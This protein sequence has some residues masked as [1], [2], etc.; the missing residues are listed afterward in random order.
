MKA[1]LP[2]S[3]LFLLFFFLLLSTGCTEKQQPI[4]SSLQVSAVTPS[5]DIPAVATKQATREDL[6][7]FVEKAV[8]FA[9][10]EG[11]AKALAGFN[12]KNGSFFDG[13]LYIYAYDFNGTTI[14]HPVNPEKIG[15]NRLYEKDA[16]GDLFIRELRDMARNGSG[17]VEYYYINPT[18]NNA[19]EKKLGYVMKVDDT[20]WLGSGIYAGTAGFAMPRSPSEP[21]TP[22]EVKAFVD[23]AV[24]FAR[25]HGK[26]AAIAEFN[27]RSG[28]FVMGNV[29]IYALDYHGI[30]LALP[31]QPDQL[32][33]DFSKLSDAAGQKF[34]QTEIDLVR[35]G[36]GFLSYLYVNPAH[37]LTVEPKVSYV[38]SVDDTYWIGAGIYPGPE[39]MVDN[40]TRRF[41][42]EAKAYA[43][44]RGKATAI[45]TFNNLSSSFIQD[46]LYV[47]AYDYNG[48]TLAYPYRPNLIG[49][50]RMN[51]TDITG[52][53]HI[54]E[55]VTSA[56]NG[57]GTVYYFTR[58]PLRNNTTEL[59]ASYLM[60]VDGTWFLGAGTYT[61]PGPSRMTHTPVPFAT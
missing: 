45:P 48:T 52:K 23:N 43:I 31:Y 58:N 9:K 27:N 13:Q 50:D 59:K 20:W 61:A 1:Y 24:D 16:A 34:T 33:Q 22:G 28:P 36:G 17:F 39:S 32:G 19:I 41:V 54:R 51:A 15:V 7:S 55:M 3:L 35:N 60:D 6:V 18:H 2:F 26:T 29:Y 25:Q 5:P 4:A 57:S 40:K 14:A 21:G 49:L 8:C 53:Q 47:F 38:R 12:Q 42:E 56:K 44:S 11:R 37:N 10:S 30:I 46:D